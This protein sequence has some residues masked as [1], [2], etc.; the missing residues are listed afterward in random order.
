MTPVSLL[1]SPIDRCAYNAVVLVIALRI[2]EVLAGLYWYV[3]PAACFWND[4]G[5]PLAVGSFSIL[6]TSS[7][8]SSGVTES[9]IGPWYSAFHLP[10]LRPEQNLFVGSVLCRSLFCAGRCYCRVSLTRIE[11][12]IDALT[13]SFR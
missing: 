2:A 6:L 7:G 5:E 1:S 13:F 3:G 12:A 8:V 10:R 4:R 11:R 9:C